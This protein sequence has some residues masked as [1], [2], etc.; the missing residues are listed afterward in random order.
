MLPYIVTAYH[1]LL[2]L[3]LFYFDGETALAAGWFSWWQLKKVVNFFEKNS[4]S[5]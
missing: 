2:P 4:A 3:Y 1:I 5:R